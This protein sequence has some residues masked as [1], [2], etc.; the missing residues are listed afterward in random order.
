MLPSD[1][2]R[3][4][5]QRLYSQHSFR[6]HFVTLLCN[7]P[8]NT[9]LI[10]LKAYLHQGLE[11]HNL[12]HPGSLGPEGGGKIT[13]AKWRIIIK[14]ENNTFTFHPLLLKSNSCC[15]AVAAGSYCHLKEIYP[16]PAEGSTGWTPGNGI[17][18]MMKSMTSDFWYVG[19]VLA[20]EPEKQREINT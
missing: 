10:I 19:K 9:W 4:Y 1:L 6:N 13:Q 8:L 3:Q 14:T 16:E 17:L 18:P 5:F 11:Q 12:N 15:T 2:K 20:K 7:N